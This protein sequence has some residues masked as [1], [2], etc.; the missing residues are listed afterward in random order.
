[1]W[2]RIARALARRLPRLGDERGSILVITALSMIV[3]LGAAGLA[4]DV[5]Q[6]YIAR[7]RLSGIADASALAAARVVRLGQTR[8][9]AAVTSV[10]GAN[11]LTNGV[12]G[13]AIT[14]TLGT[15]SKG[16][17]TVAVGVT[18]PLALLFGGV[19]RLNSVTVQSGAV[20]ASPPVDLVMVLDQSQSLTNANAWDDL[21]FAAK[22]F[23]GFFGDGYDKLALVSFQSV[24][25]MRNTLSF[26]FRSA[27]TTSINNLSSFGSTNAAEGLRMA[28]DELNSSRVQV[29]SLKAV[30]FFTDG[31]ANT[32]RTT[33]NGTDL[34][35]GVHNKLQ[36]PD[37]DYAH[38][39]K[40]PG[41]ISTQYNVMYDGD[42]KGTKL[43]CPQN[44]YSAAY[45]LA[46]SRQS[47]LDRANELRAKGILV[48]TIGL[49][50]TAKGE[51]P[52]MDFL[53]RIANEDGIVNPDQPQAKAYYAP[54]A[55]QL[56]EIFTRVAADLMVHLVS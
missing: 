2:G 40:N 18:Q 5:G 31:W 21:Q 16:H 9:V 4:L 1:M 36:A 52:D 11:G 10:A 26:T 53:R 14:V 19:I 54:S 15:D 37:E 32:Y 3:L 49:K 17:Q 7:S 6:L 39:I 47:A 24:A 13:V 56:Q 44:P 29:G 28:R 8:A 33:I 12:N 20:A 42:C 30:I 34:V 35:L 22:T 46:Q 43:P 45:V 48:Y 51:D 50:D 25:A 55:S 41:T 38:Y 27:V 23:V